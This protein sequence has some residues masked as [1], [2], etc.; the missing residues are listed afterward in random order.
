MKKLLPA[1]FCL[2]FFAAQSQT[3]LIDYFNYGTTADTLCGNG[4]VTTNWIAHVNSGIVPVGYQASSLP[5]T[6]YPPTTNT[7]GSATVA[8]GSTTR[9][10]VNRQLP[11]I[12]SGQLYISFLIRA[13]AP[14]LTVGASSYNL[15]FNDTFGALLSAN[16]YA[17]FF[18]KSSGITSGLVF[19][20]S[21]ASASTS[22]QFTT[23]TYSTSSAYLIV[24]RYTFNTST[25]TDDVVNAWIL[26]SGTVP[27]TPPTPTLTA[28]DVVSD[29]VRIQSVCLRQGTGVG[30]AA[31]DAI[32]VGTNWVDVV[33]PVAL[34][35]F[36]A[37]KVENYVLLK[38]STAQE[39]NNDYFEIE[40]SL[41]NGHWSLAG[42]VN[43]NGTTNSISNYQLIDTSAVLSMTNTLYYRLKQVDFNGKFEYSKHIAIKLNEDNKIEIFPNPFKN[44]L[45][46]SNTNSKSRLIEI[47][48]LT[49]RKV[50]EKAISDSEVKMDLNSISE[51]GL[52]FLKVDEWFFKIYKD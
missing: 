25:S 49:G 39:A 43:G 29:I 24:L 21:K 47:F 7:G 50:F 27:I 2:I 30:T 35:N 15:C 13:S 40:K 20:V 26:S 48:D 16:N 19:G 18:F 22:A 17:R 34:T 32:R 11:L 5:F 23:T 41:D 1:I 51:K 4:G 14:G 12:S 6:G 28:T 44:E 46:I 45:I 9:E 42:K 8:N 31:I 3:Y 10:S 52:Y 33:L 38:W 36:E 37:K